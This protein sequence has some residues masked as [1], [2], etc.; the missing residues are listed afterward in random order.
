MTWTPHC[1]ARG[2]NWGDA[3]ANDVMKKALRKDV[4]YIFAV[5]KAKIYVFRD[6]S[7]YGCGGR[8]VKA[9][10]IGMWNDV[11]RAISLSFISMPGLGR[12]ILQPSYNEA[13]PL[14]ATQTGLDAQLNGFMRQG[15]L[16]PRHSV[17]PRATPEWYGPARRQ[18]PHFHSR[19]E[20]LI[21]TN[22][23]KKSL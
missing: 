10:L 16:M 3:A 5:G 23:L 13:E 15:P 12:G 14:T 8:T 2:T 9:L 20:T 22:L 19:V 6:S 1:E 21:I 18:L 4:A 7:R 17:G 11:E